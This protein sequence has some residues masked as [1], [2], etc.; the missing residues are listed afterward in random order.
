MDILGIIDLLEIRGVS[1]DHHNLLEICIVLLTRILLWIFWLGLGVGSLVCF[2][3][4]L[5][6]SSLA[7][8]GSLLF[9][10]RVLFGTSWFYYSIYCVLSI[11]IIII[12]IRI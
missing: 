5:V 2:L 8:F 1:Q 11:K 4:G 12:I 9:T 3:P 7:P 6:G 10:S